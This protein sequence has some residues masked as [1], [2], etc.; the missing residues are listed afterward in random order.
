MMYSP[1]LSAA[2]ANRN[3]RRASLNARKRSLT[4]HGVT[5]G[6]SGSGRSLL[7]STSGSARLSFSGRKSLGHDGNDAETP[8]PL[9][10]TYLE[11]VVLEMTVTKKH[12]D[13]RYVLTVR[14]AELNAAWRH[15]RSFD[16]Y[17]KLQQRLIKKLQHGHFCNADCPWLYGFLKSYFPKKLVFTFS[18]AKVVES[19]K[20]TLE[21][22]FAALLGFLRDR[23]NHCCS[24]VMTGFADELVEFIYG[25]ALQQYGLENPQKS[26]PASA[27]ALL[28]RRSE[29]YS[30]RWDDPPTPDKLKELRTQPSLTNSSFTGSLPDDDAVNDPNCG[31]CGLC[32]SSLC[33]VAFGSSASTSSLT[34]SN[35]S[36]SEDDSSGSGS[37]RTNSSAGVPPLSRSSSND[38]S[39]SGVFTPPWLG[40]TR[41][42]SSKGSANSFGSGRRSSSAR[43]RAA[44]YYLTTLS[45]GHQFHDECIVPKLNE[46]LKCPTC[47]RVQLND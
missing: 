40:T 41:Q 35:P 20:Q 3:K 47:G 43:R 46:S 2:L 42:A 9:A 24:V 33:G 38:A 39:H 37:S 6:A 14:H 45:C 8:V 5:S 11:Q 32:G 44:T 27:D 15:A 29:G 28:G 16:E 17:R 22:F 4:D 25:D 23:K 36:L 1:E 13:V 12:A 26:A 30:S 19:R 10:V 18:S 31:D 7:P 34:F 21:R